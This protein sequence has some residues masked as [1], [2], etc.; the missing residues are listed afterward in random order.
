M[1][2][3]L[4]KVNLRKK[5]AGVGGGGKRGG[6]EWPLWFLRNDYISAQAGLNFCFQCLT[7]SMARS[8]G[9]Q[10]GSISTLRL[11]TRDGKM[12]LSSRSGLPTLTV[13]QKK[14]FS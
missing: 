2:Y 10:D 14:K 6:G 4:K 12:E 5:V 8:V 9:G 13:S 3:R 7:I 1:T 11:A